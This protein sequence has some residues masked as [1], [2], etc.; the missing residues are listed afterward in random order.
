MGLAG[1]GL[2]GSNVLGQANFTNN[3]QA[4]T[5]SGLGLATGVLFD[6]SMNRLF[7]ADGN[8]SP[9]F[10]NRILV[11]DPS[12]GLTTGQAASFVLGQP[13]FTSTGSA[14]AQSRLPSPTGV[15]LDAAGTFF[16]VDPSNS[17]I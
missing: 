11:F 2:P 1:G 6:A 4:T 12:G 7:V 10:N 14:T 3:G 5:P 9:S 17:R 13:T 8:Q 16:A 15:P